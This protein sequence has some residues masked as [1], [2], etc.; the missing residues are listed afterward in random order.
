[1]NFISTTGKCFGRIKM[2]HAL[3]IKN[4][5]MKIFQTHIQH[6]KILKDRSNIQYF[7]IYWQSIH[8]LEIRGKFIHYI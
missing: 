6:N 5:Q 8:S 7:L 3:I 1:M 4:N 2:I